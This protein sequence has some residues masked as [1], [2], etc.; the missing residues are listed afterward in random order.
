MT[1]NKIELQVLNISNSQAQAGAYAL[2]MGETNGSRQLPIII[3]SAEA[4]A[5]LIELRKI[6]PPRPMT[7]H[8]FA[9][10]L[11]ALGVKL[12]RTLIY[13]VENGIFYSYIYL[14]SND[15]I[16]RADSRTS[17]AIILCL[18]TNAPILIYEDILEAER[19]RADNDPYSSPRQDIHFDPDELLQ[20]EKLDNLKVA[21]QRA[22]DEEN[23]EQ[24][25]Q[26]RDQINQMEKQQKE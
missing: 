2:V 22:I 1:R 24:A 17:D 8:L 26:L 23:Y 12:L 13:R 14:K 11:E 5:V 18:H 3:G 15:A 19:M 16:I 9:S 4:Q 10:I 25:A 7:H 6:V 21:L 20:E